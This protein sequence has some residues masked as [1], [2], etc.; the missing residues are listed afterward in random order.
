MDEIDIF[1]LTQ[2]AEAGMVCPL[3]DELFA[4]PLPMR[5]KVLKQIAK[6]AESD[7]TGAYTPAVELVPDAAST[8][9]PSKSPQQ[10]EKHALTFPQLYTPVTMGCITGRPYG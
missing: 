5:M 9:P 1:K 10:S 3:C 2:Q 4:L 8:N 7:K 6:Q